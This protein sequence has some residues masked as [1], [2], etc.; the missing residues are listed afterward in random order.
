MRFA[1]LCADLPKRL[2]GRRGAAYRCQRHDGVWG[3]TIADQRQ[4]GRRLDRASARARTHDRG[5]GGAAPRPNGGFPPTCLPRCTRR[6]VPHAA[7]ALARRR[8]RRSRDLQPGH[9]GAGGGRC[10]PGLVS[11]AG[12]GELARRRLSRSRRSRARSF[13]APDALV[14]WG[15]PAGVAKALAVDGGYRVTGKWRFASGSANATWM[16]GHSTVFERR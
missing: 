8:R 14:A 16:G 6:P 5:G 15:P 11:G 1:M 2:F 7:A 13:G 4:R 9:R 12:G 10:Q 3:S